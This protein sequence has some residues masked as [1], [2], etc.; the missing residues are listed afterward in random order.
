MTIP[1]NSTYDEATVLNPSSAVTD[2]SL[3]V[4]LS[5]MSAAWWS[6]AENTN[7][8]RMRF[9]KGDGTEIAGHVIEYDHASRTG[10]ARVKWSGTLA[11]SGTQTL[12]VYPPVS[13]NDIYTDGNDY[14][15]DNAYDASWLWYTPGDE[16]ENVLEPTQSLTAATNWTSNTSTFG[17]ST[18]SVQYDGVGSRADCYASYTHGSDLVSDYPVYLSMWMWSD[19]LTDRS[20]L[21]YPALIGASYDTSRPY[22][23]VT[24][25]SADMRVLMD[26]VVAPNVRHS[27]TVGM[28]DDTWYM[29]GGRFTGSEV[30]SIHNGARIDTPTSHSESFDAGLDS[31]TIHPRY[32]CPLGYSCE[33]QVHTEDRSEAWTTEEFDQVDDQAA[34][35]GTWENVAAPS[36]AASYNRVKG[37]IKN[38][39]LIGVQAATNAWV[40]IQVDQPLVKG[41][42][43]SNA[44]STTIQVNYGGT[45]DDLNEE[46]YY[47]LGG[48]NVFIATPNINRIFIKGGG[49]ASFIAQ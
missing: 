15:K 30:Q 43:I 39:V 8:R 24:T 1:A 3:L 27:G 9:A 48:K 35:W 34:F 17:K 37:S 18:G 45:S 36:A 14:G 47:L 6:A 49:T 2:F 23:T 46:G 19:D 12:R 21:Q 10:W 7:K 29:M 40:P 44:D 11:A 31:V 16:M 5:R 25:S 33:V 41:V 22:W 38:P 4:D 42:R 28:V 13:T 26:R 20:G 32:T